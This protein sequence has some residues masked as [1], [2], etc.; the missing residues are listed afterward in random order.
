MAR[1]KIVPQ[2]GLLSDLEYTSVIVSYSTGIDST[3]ALYWALKNFPKEKIYLLYCDTGC[4]YPENERIFHRVAAFL[5]IKAVILCREGGYLGH[6]LEER[7]KFPDAKNRW[8]TAYL[9]TAVTD[10]W[11]RQHRSELGAK[12][13]FLSGERRDE[14]PARAK[15]PALEYHST[16]LKTK[17]VADFVCHWYRPYLDQEKEKMFELGKRLGLEPHPCYE[18]VGRCSCM[19]CMLMPDRHAS[20]NI[21]RYPEIAEKW[22]R[23]ELEIGHRWKKNKSLQAVYNEC[24]DIDDIDDELLQEY[25]QISLFELPKAVL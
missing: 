9:K 19:F 5:G 16:T 14:S 21:K 18:Y 11:I 23:A 8:C 22:V 10:H 17:R 6:L 24:M 4:E 20:E 25:R 15:L 12:C 1:T 2:E 3:G 13:L 7:R